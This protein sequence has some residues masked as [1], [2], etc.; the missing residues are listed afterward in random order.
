MMAT[1]K[2]AKNTLAQIE[3]LKKNKRVT[4]NNIHEEQAQGILF[5]YNYINVIT[6]YKHHFSKWDKAGNEVKNDGKH[7][8]ERDVEFSEYFNLFKDERSQYPNLIRNILGYELR[9]KSIMAYRILTSTEI[10]NENELV[11][12]LESVRLRIPMNSDYSDSRLEHMNNHIKQLEKSICDYADIYCFFDRMSLGVSLTIFAGLDRGLQKLLL[13]DF[14]KLDM[15]FKVQN[16]NDFIDKVFTLVAIRNCVMHC[17]SLEILVRYYNPA[18]HKLRKNRNKKKYAKM[19]NELSIEK[20]YA[21][22]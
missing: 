17:N 7:I 13:K 16:I 12:Y 22:I 14:E 11:A 15:N 18:T 20:Q 6:P 1:Y 10:N 4:F 3:Y 5:K 2:P 9:F 21:Q 8:Y 19:I